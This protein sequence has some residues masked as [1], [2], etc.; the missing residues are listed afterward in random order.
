MFAFSFVRLSAWRLL[1]AALALTAAALC[2]CSHK[3]DAP[4]APGYYDGPMTKATKTNAKAPKSG[5]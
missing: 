1:G 2:G 5:E 3:D 4:S